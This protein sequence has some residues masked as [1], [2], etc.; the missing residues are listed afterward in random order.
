MTRTAAPP[1]EGAATASRQQDGLTHRQIMTII[2]GL[3]LGMFLAA[4]DQTI[5]STA[6]RTISDQLN[7]LSLQAWATTAYLITATISTPLYGKLS[8]LYGRKPFFLAAIT[9]FLVGSVAC[10]FSQSMYELAA[11]RAVQGLG[12]GGLM[13][14][15]L[16][17]LGDIVPPRQRA[18]Y[19]GYFMSVFGISSVVGPVIGGFFAGQPEILTLAGWRWVFLVNVPIG[20]IA[21]IVVARV[22]NI[23][24]TRREHRIDW[25]GAIAISVFLVPLL[26]VAEQGRDWGWDSRNA[27]ICYIVGAVG[28]LLFLL[29]E[30]LMKDE[31]LIPLRLFRNGVF[32]VGTL[33]GLLVGMAMFGGVA[34]IPQYLQIVQ[35]ASPTKAGL[36]ML[37]FVLGLLV[38]SVFSGQVTSRTGHYK[39]FPLL[40]TALIVTGA[41]LF[42]YRVNAD[43]PLWQVD[44]YMAVIGLGLGNCMQTL[45]VALQNAM[46]AKDMGVATSAATFSRQMGGTIGTAVFISALFS[47]VADRIRNAFQDIAPTADFQAALHDPAVL[48]DPNNRPVL[49]IMRQAATGGGANA[50][51][52][53]QDSS[54]IQRLDPRLARP[55]LVGFA[56]SMQTVFLLVAAAAALAFLVL[57]FLKQIP[58]RTQSGLQARAADDAAEQVSVEASVVEPISTNGHR[59]LTP[60]QEQATIVTGR[61]HARPEVDRPLPALAVAQSGNGFAPISAGSSVRG[62][63]RRSDGAPVTHAVLT[64]IDPAGHQAGRG[65]P[66]PDGGYHLDAPGSGTYV[67][68]ASADAHQPQA[69]SVTIGDSTAVLDVTLSGNSELTG[70]VRDTRGQTPVAGALVTLA[71]AR[72]EVVATRITAEDGGYRFEDTVSGHYTLAV[73]ATTFRPSARTVTIPD[74]GEVRQ[75]VELSGSVQ[76][77][78]LALTTVDNRP[79]ADAR[80]TLLDEDGNTVATTNTNDEGE[81]AFVDVPEGDYTVV[82]TGYPPVTANLRLTGGERIQHNVQLGHTE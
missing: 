76:L 57:L 60:Y 63:V 22:L 15:A 19:T 42:H 38:G 28:L 12:G 54:F 29:C 16:A 40:G 31:A 7:G 13:S 27:W 30:A 70:T 21:L 10:T 33:G 41:L 62:T 3:M 66:R 8:D 49:D 67:L 61:H 25:F 71:D 65:R 72:G 2:S 44:I 77:H 68:I 51:G 79:I 6:I 34:L 37:P 46:P 4:L 47:T 59:E 36:L 82:A 69:S 20:A 50:G 24:H 11:F 39:I 52:A 17:I 26:I 78:G 75:D 45:T 9:I 43:T 53:L 74:S 1:A 35:G 73:S 56:D 5:V 58:L 81:Y 55:F 14:L 80:V 18:K 23:P 64:L 32:S 48:S